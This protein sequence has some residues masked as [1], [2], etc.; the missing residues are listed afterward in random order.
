MLWTCSHSFFFL[1]DLDVSSLQGRVK[2][3]LEVKNKTFILAT[4]YCQ[5]LAD[6]NDES[7]RGCEELHIIIIF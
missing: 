6:K 4:P 1:I 7:F 2:C 5:T 3:S